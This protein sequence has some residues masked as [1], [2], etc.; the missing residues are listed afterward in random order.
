MSAGTTAAAVLLTPEELS[1]K[2]ANRNVNEFNFQTNE[3][4]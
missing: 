3:P 2:H 4:F 1:A